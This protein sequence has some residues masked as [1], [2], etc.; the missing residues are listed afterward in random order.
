MGK[1]LKTQGTVVVNPKKRVAELS[2][3]VERIVPRGWKR[4]RLAEQILRIIRRDGVLDTG[5]GKWEKY[6]EELGTTKKE[7]YMTLRLLRRVGLIRKE[8]GHHRGVWKLSRQFSTALRD[9]ADFWERWAF[10]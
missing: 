10:G 2:D 7:F 6:I 1:L 3:L 4:R 8:G 9:L 5:E